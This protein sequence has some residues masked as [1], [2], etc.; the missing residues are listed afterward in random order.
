MLKSYGICN[1]RSL[2]ILV[3]FNHSDCGA[4][5]M[6]QAVALLWAW[7]FDRGMLAIQHE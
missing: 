5:Q 6:A 7:I 1:N 3:N 4:T 2:R